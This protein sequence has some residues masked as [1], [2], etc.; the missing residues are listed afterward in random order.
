VTLLEVVVDD[1]A[2]SVFHG[3]EIADYA[4]VCARTASGLIPIV[5][6]FRPILETMTLEFP[7]GIVDAGEDPEQAAGREFLEET[8]LQAKRLVSLGSHWTDTGRLSNRTHAYFAEADDPVSR[9][10]GEAELEL[11][12]ITVSQLEEAINNGSFSHFLH[13]AVYLLAKSRHLV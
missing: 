3:L 13:V 12:L 2:R 10:S 1:D 11:D 9:K 6:Q 7:A 5:R 8:G 4:I